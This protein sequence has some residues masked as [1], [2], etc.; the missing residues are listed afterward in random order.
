MCNCAIAE[1]IPQSTAGWCTQITVCAITMQKCNV[2]MR[3]SVM[4]QQK[5]SITR[6]SSLMY[7]SHYHMPNGERQFVGLFQMLI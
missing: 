1:Q 2:K 7:Y 4:S 6:S 5:L 3:T